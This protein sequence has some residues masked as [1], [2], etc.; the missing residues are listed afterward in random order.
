MPLEPNLDSIFKS[1]QWTPIGEGNFNSA[2]ISEKELTINGY[3]GKWVF[4]QPSCSSKY[5][6]IDRAIRKWNLHNPDYSVFKFK[7]GWLVPY[8]GKTPASDEQIAQKLVEIYQN[9]GEIIVD[10]CGKNN[11]LFFQNKVICIDMDLSLRRGSFASEDYFKDSIPYDVHRDYLAYFSSKHQKPKTVSVTQTLLYLEQQLPNYD[12]HQHIT[13]RLIQWLHEFRLTEA[14]LTQDILDTLLN[15]AQ[16][17]SAQEIKDVYFSVDFINT[18]HQLKQEHGIT[19]KQLITLAHEQLWN[20]A[21]WA[22]A[23]NKDDTLEAVTAAIQANASCINKKGPRGYTLLHLAAMYPHFN[24]VRYLMDQGADLNLLTPT[25]TAETAGIQ[26]PG[27][28]AIE[29]ALQSGS[30]VVKLLAEKGAVIPPE[31][32]T[33]LPKTETDESNHA[34]ALTQLYTDLYYLATHTGNLSKT[35]KESLL[36]L[37]KAHTQLSIWQLGENG[38]SFV[39]CAFLANNVPVIN[40]LGQLPEWQAL[41]QAKNKENGWTLWHIAAHMG[42]TQNC[43]YLKAIDIHAVTK[44]SQSSALHVASNTNNGLLCKVLLLHGAN[45]MLK[46]SFGNTPENGWDRENRTN[47]FTEF[48]TELYGLATNTGN[49]SGTKKAELRALIKQHTHFLTWPLT[50][51]KTVE[52]VW[53][54]HHPL[55]KNIFNAFCRAQNLEQKKDQICAHIKTKT[56]IPSLY[57]NPSKTEMMLESLQQAITQATFKLADN[58]DK[59]ADD[60]LHHTINHWERKNPNVNTTTT[61]MLLFS[62]TTGPSSLIKEVLQ[63]IRTLLAPESRP[64]QTQPITLVPIFSY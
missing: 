37:I 6:N 8:F 51:G 41:S 12:K 22:S 26:Y 43:K 64:S 50:H 7:D 55:K 16:I 23:P 40:E 58:P 21:W 1:T 20:P 39:F 19:K 61:Y 10:A 63:N 33:L 45:P 57:F 2:C 52:E 44:R 11:F 60:V 62:Q 53:C 34:E 31:I 5:N 54:E 4:K 48:S 59:T 49:L 13:P 32:I 14:S 35:K 9:T 56:P 25:T 47:P 3:T 42:H 46:D 36:S 17:D 29:I 38:S 27:M 24:L 30:Y 15:V 28:T 18:L